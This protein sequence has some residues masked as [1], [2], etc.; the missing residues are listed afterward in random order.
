M[1]A[2]RMVPEMEWMGRQEK[3]EGHSDAHS[4]GAIDHGRVVTAVAV[5][6]C[7]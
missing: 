5:I 6:D 2:T 1:Q 3:A 7:N 4:V